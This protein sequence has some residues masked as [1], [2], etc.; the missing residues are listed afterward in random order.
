MC[1][2]ITP[3]R[4]IT[5]IVLTLLLARPAFPQLSSQNREL[6]QQMLH[7]IANDVRKH[8]YDPQFHGVDWDAKVLEAKQRIDKAASMDMALS[9]IAAVLDLLHDSH[10]FFVPPSHAYLHDYGWQMQMVGDRCLVVRVRPTSDAEV[11]GMKPGDQVMGINGFRVSRDNLWKM[12]YFYN[13]LRPQP[14]LRVDLDDTVGVSRQLAISAKVR[15]MNRVEDFGPSN[16]W[17]LVRRSEN[18]ENQLRPRVAELS[19]QLMVLKLPEFVV[20]G[21]EIGS[22]ARKARKHKALIVDLRG[23]PGGSVETLQ[24]MVGS[25]F[26]QKVK[27]ADRV[28]RDATK[29]LMAKP[30]HEDVFLGKL[31]VLVDSR[32]AS[33]SEVFARTIQIE[34]RG[35]VLG[36]HTSGS[37][38]EAKYYSH[39]SGADTVTFFGA[40]ITDADLIMTD[41]QSLE[42][43][44]VTPDEIVLPTP[45][46][47]KKGD[48]PVLARAAELLGV[49]LSPEQAGKLLP[50]EWPHEY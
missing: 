47:F 2:N 37:V 24:Y 32:S 1:A 14:A 22:L 43:V 17:D 10:V 50:Y 34:K 33:A 11:K 15:L 28:E 30:G 41:G 26:Q 27:I 48:D 40:S 29:P 5:L 13:V 7:D 44:G 23:N 12:E 19:D 31:I 46:D 38:M 36:D 18:A 8:C 42:H 35:A 3:L 20:S 6:A 4:S 21:D 16:I 45:S 49:K 39:E 9:E 25:F